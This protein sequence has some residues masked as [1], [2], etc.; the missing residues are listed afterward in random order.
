MESIRRRSLMVAD[1]NENKMFSDWVIKAMFGNGGALDNTGKFTRS[2]TWTTIVRECGNLS[3]KDITYLLVAEK[4]PTLA[5]FRV[6]FRRLPRGSLEEEQFSKSSRSYL[7]SSRSLMIDGFW[8]PS[9]ILGFYRIVRDLSAN[10]PYFQ[11]GCDAV[12]K[13]AYLALVEVYLRGYATSI[14]AAVPIL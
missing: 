9:G 10:C 11:E 1:I 2:S 7:S 5:L 13:A 8:S 12:G 6:P 4:N 3:S 14:Y